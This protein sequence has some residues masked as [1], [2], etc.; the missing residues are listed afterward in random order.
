LRTR[1]RSTRTPS[2]SW[3]NVESLWLGSKRTAACLSSSNVDKL[4]YRLCS[5]SCTTIFCQPGQRDEL[6]R[7]CEEASR[8]V[9]LNFLLQIRGF[10]IYGWSNL[11]GAV[12]FGATSS[13]PLTNTAWKWSLTE[14]SDMSNRLP[15]SV[16]LATLR[17]RL[18]QELLE[19]YEQVFPRRAHFLEGHPPA[20][21]TKA[22]CA[23]FQLKTESAK[24]K[25]WRWRHKQ[26]LDD[27]FYYRTYHLVL[28]VS[29]ERKHE[30]T[31]TTSHVL[32]APSTWT[33]SHNFADGCWMLCSL[34][35][36]AKSSFCGG[37]RAQNWMTVPLS[38]VLKDGFQRIRGGELIIA[39]H[40][41]DFLFQAH[42][43]PKTSE[44]QPAAQ[45]RST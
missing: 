39:S 5:P 29:G 31:E 30:Q 44:F 28:Q 15:L 18:S 35:V 12:D 41:L 14:F 10:D 7:G 38:R 19:E 32:D 27:G 33:D 2:R 37:R 23:V 20:K 24:T 34:I 36:S 8:A 4:T 13:S 9:R 40:F 45:S 21:L 26:P 6:P 17:A 22:S 1:E 25:D 43:K 11:F 42:R 3:W 16:T